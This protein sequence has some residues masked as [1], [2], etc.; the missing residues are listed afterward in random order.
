MYR[1]EALHITSSSYFNETAF[2][3]EDELGENSLFMALDMDFSHDPLTFLNQ[4]F[5]MDFSGNDFISGAFREI[6]DEHQDIDIMGQVFAWRE[7]EPIFSGGLETL[8]FPIT[9][10]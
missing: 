2:M 3:I 6:I 7:I 10:E 8:D 1:L 9:E 5:S 4:V